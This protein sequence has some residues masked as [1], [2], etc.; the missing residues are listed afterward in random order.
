MAKEM[1]AEG[2]NFF[3]VVPGR[4]FDG[5]GAGI[6]QDAQGD[7]DGVTLLFI[8]FEKEGHI[9]LAKAVLGDFDAGVVLFFF[10]N[11]GNGGGA[12]GKVVRIGFGGIENLEELEDFCGSQGGGGRGEAIHAGLGDVGDELAKVFDGADI[13]LLTKPTLIAIGPPVGEVLALNGFAVE[14]G[15]KDF[16]DRGEFVKPSEGF[17]IFFSIKDALVDLFAEFAG[18]PGDFAELRVVVVVVCLRRVFVRRDGLNDNFVVHPAI[19]AQEE[20]NR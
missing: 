14:V 11:D 15:G 9:A 13:L 17:R 19:L 20:K 8:F 16:P 6:A 7:G 10:T 12:F 5:C 18:E 3:G 4:A 2:F 1:N